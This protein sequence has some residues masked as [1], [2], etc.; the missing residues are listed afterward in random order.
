MKQHPKKHHNL[1][2]ERKKRGWAQEEVAN[3]IG[4]HSK[5][6]SRWERGL[7]TPSLYYQQKLAEIFEQSI[8]ELGFPIEPEEQSEDDAQQNNLFQE[9]WKEA[10]SSEPFYGRKK[11]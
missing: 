1:Q 2:R 9:D 7:S 4:G 8:E 5:T 6:V 3:K 11:E 10:P